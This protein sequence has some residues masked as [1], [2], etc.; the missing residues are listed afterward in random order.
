M[1]HNLGAR[2]FDGGPPGLLVQSLEWES[3]GREQ[4]G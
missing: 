2:G 4:Y 1:V 3:L